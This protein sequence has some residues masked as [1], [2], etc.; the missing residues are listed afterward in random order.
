MFVFDFRV[1]HWRM[2]EYNLNK[3]RMA[4]RFFCTEMS[5]SALCSNYDWV[6]GRVGCSKSETFR[7]IFR[8]TVLFYKFPH[9]YCFWPTRTMV[10]SGLKHSGA[11]R[12][13]EIARPRM[14]TVNFSQRTFKNW[15]FTLKEANGFVKFLFRHAQWSGVN[16]KHFRVQTSHIS[17]MERNTNRS[18][19]HRHLLPIPRDSSRITG[20]RV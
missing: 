6:I 20:L 14:S 15:Q 16:G 18:S 7:D 17:N 11:A 13:P 12:A 4:Q 10:E 19:S 8:D 1:S 9:C 3:C 5:V 2:N